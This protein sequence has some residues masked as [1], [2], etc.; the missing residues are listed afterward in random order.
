MK[1]FEVTFLTED[2]GTDTCIVFAS[3]K[4]DAENKVANKKECCAV[5][6][7]IEVVIT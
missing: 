3:S 1:L 7:A 6:S 2:A 4:P 5:F